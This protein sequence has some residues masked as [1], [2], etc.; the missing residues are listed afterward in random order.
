MGPK[1]MRSAMSCLGE[2]GDNERSPVAVRKGGRPKEKATLV[3]WNEL[4][5][6]FNYE[7]GFHLL[8]DIREDL[9]TP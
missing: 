9:Q 1:N 3:I 5:N 6:H 2:E 7:G 4:I 8:S